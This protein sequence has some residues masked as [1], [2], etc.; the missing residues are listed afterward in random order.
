MNGHK[1][2]ARD[3]AGERERLRGPGA[4]SALGCP[5]FCGTDPPF[6]SWT[7]LFSPLSWG[8]R[9]ATARHWPSPEGVA[10][11]VFLSLGSFGRA[12]LLLSGGYA[13]QPGPGQK[14]REKL[15]KL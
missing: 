14:G 1:D 6:V 5:C 11:A 10:A 3:Q 4:S 15:Q 13:P 8:F 2:V 12:G 7:N 9:A